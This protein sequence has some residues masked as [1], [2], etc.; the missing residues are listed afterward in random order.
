M[1]DNKKYGVIDVGSNSVRAMLYSGGKILYTDLIITRLGEGLIFTGKLSEIAMERTAAAVFSF[2]DKLKSCGADEVFTFATEAVR[3]ASNSSV[4]I[5]K[6][7]KT[8][9]SLDVVGGDEEGELG[10][11][12]ALG[13]KDGAIIDIG[14]ASAEIV[15]A[16]NGKIIYSHSLPLGAVRLHDM[17]GENEPKLAA[18]ID[19]KLGEYGVLPKSAYT[20]VGGTATALCVVAKGFD[21][22][23][24]E[25]VNGQFLTVEEISSALE[26]IKAC[27]L[28]E[29]ERKLK[30]AEKRAEIIYGGATLLYRILTRFSI[31]KIKIST[32]DN[33]VGYIRK[34]I[35]G[36][37]YLK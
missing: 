6:I 10:L 19:E 25:R 4:F 36:E 31:D 7:A 35:Y 5:E 32:D 21:G 30:I 34:K 26:K 16:K 13:G 14:G 27:P 20:A 8:G 33:L 15:A 29:R 24:E 12:G 2:A 9:L 28:E 18:K 23:T 11:I 1:T 22:F 3:S 17:C 37:G